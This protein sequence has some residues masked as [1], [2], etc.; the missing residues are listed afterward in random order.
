MA[1]GDADL[2]EM[3]KLGFNFITSHM[4]SELAVLATD[5]E[6]FPSELSPFLESTGSVKKA[7][8]GKVRSF[9]ITFGCAKTLLKTTADTGSPVSLACK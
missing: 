1:N 5:N 9:Q 2:D 3:T 7:A 8:T 4:E 6:I